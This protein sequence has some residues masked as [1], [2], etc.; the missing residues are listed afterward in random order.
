[1]YISVIKC[2][3]CGHIYNDDD[4]HK[5]EADLW[6]IAPNE[7][8]VVEKCQSCKKTIYIS[9]G[10]ITIYKTFASEEDMDDDIHTHT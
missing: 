5:A 7:E 1:M 3:H 8:K 10:Y 9:G 6:A 2:P 4:M